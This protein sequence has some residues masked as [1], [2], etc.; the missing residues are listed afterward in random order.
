[1]EFYNGNEWR[2]FRY[3]ADIKNSRSSRGRRGVIYGGGIY[4]YS[5][6]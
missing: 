6:D 2:Q 1:M 4:K 5:S 3:Q